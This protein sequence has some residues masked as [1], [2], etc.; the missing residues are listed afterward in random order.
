MTYPREHRGVVNFTDWHPIIF[1]S[2]D[3]PVF[4][5]QDRLSD[6]GDIISALDGVP[7]RMLAEHQQ[8]PS[9]VA[10]AF[11]RFRPAV[12]SPTVKGVDA[13][14]LPSRLWPLSTRWQAPTRRYEHSVLPEPVLI[15]T[16]RLFATPR[17]DWCV[18]L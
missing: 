5:C 3:K 4:P 13:R 11:L 18:G 7:H 8:N 17:A 16:L 9:S 14:L 1:D 15:A 6:A 10:D 2:A 12:V